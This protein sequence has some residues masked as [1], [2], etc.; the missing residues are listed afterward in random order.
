MLKYKKNNTTV[1]NTGPPDTENLYYSLDMDGA[2]LKSSFLLA[3]I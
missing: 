3:L 2:T 1:V